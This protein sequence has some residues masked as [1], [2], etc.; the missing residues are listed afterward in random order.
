MKTTSKKLAILAL[1]AVVSASNAAEIPSGNISADA[2]LVL[3]NN[4]YP[5]LDWNITYPSDITTIV[6][7]TPPGGIVPKTDLTLHVRCLAADVQ[8]RREYW[9]GWKWV[10]SYRYISVT[11]Y[12]RKNSNNWRLLFDNTQPYVNPSTIVW[13]E[14][15]EEG[16]EIKFA[17]KANYSGGKWYYSGEGSSN[18]LVLKN[19]DYPP[20]YATWDTQS[21]LGTHIAPY[22]D[23]NGAVDIGPRD[24]IVAFEL[25]HSMSSQ[26]SSGDMQDMIYLLTFQEDDDI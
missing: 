25:T 24:L 2:K 11:G 9:N 13:N 1:L 22:L 4:V 23:E 6:T 3:A 8:E 16:D 10:V 20:S 15:L 21:T 19:G 12:G 14:E 7:V 26:G 5:K 18:V 17:S